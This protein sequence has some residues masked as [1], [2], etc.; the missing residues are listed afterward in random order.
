M[1]FTPFHLGPALAFGLP[2]RRYIH[3]PTFIVGN[4]IL[5]VEGFLVL[6]LGLNYPLHGY[7]HTFLLAATVGL[8]LAFV[9][10]KL[11]KPMQP[12]YRKIQF[13]SNSPLKLRSFLLA[14]VLGAALHVFFDAFL[15]SEMAPFFPLTI[16]PL[17]NVISMSDV[18]LLCFGLGIF[19]IA[20]YVALLA[21]SMYT[22]K[23]QTLTFR[24]SSL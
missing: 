16:N 8:L 22:K 15:Y 11:E 20:Y 4:V 6:T 10:F 18:Y 2:L 23:K 13:E 5:D 7:L 12:L 19:G 1:P 14:G 24:P 17:L 3:A 21:Y 9:M